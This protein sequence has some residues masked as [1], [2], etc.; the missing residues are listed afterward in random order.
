MQPKRIPNVGL[1][2][3]K[4]PT[5]TVITYP[6][7]VLSDVTRVLAPPAGNVRLSDES[8]RNRPE[9]TAAR[10]AK[11]ADFGAMAAAPSVKKRPRAAE[12]VQLRRTKAAS[13]KPS[14]PSG[15]LVA[16]YPGYAGVQ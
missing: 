14:E 9:E 2:A 1:L 13:R 12:R 8:P 5:A 7:G 6:T 4:P 11:P 16:A 3:Y 10:T 15:G